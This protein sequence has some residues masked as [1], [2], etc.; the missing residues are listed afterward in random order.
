ML[1]LEP[2]FFVPSLFITPVVLVFAY[3][4]RRKS[5]NYSRVWWSAVAICVLLTALFTWQVIS[6][7]LYSERDHS[8]D[9]PGGFSVGL[10][11]VLIVFL[12]GTCVV[13]PAFPVLIGLALLPPSDLRRIAR[14][15]LIAT[16]LIYVGVSTLLIVQKNMRYVSDYRQTKQQ[17]LLQR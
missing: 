10:F 11:A 8:P 9:N 4:W 3:F 14:P 13:I 7:P 5:D 16:C 12:A 17:E 2:I 1:P 6:A 15:L